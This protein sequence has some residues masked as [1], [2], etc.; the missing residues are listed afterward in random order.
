MKKIIKTFFLAIFLLLLSS[1]V[2]ASFINSVNMDIYIDSNGNA[3][4]T[5]VWDCTPTS[6]TEIYHPYYNLGN[7]EITNLTVSENG[8]EYIFLDYWLYYE[9]LS[10]KKNKCGIRS[11]VDSDSS[12]DR[13]F[14]KA[15]CWGIGSYSNHKY[16]VKYTIT[17]FVSELKDSQM[18]YF[19]FFP[20]HMYQ[21]I[22]KV[23][24]KIYSDF[25]IPSSIDVWGYE[26]PDIG[27]TAHVCNGYI[28]ME[29]DST[30]YAAEERMTILVKFPTGT[31]NTSNKLKNSFNYYYKMA[32]KHN[33]KFYNE[34]IETIFQVI[35]IFFIPPFIILYIQSIPMHR[36]L[37]NRIVIISDYW[38]KNENSLDYCSDIPCD[39]DIF[40]AFYVGYK[41]KIIKNKTDLLGALILKWIKEG[42]CSSKKRLVGI[43]R[44]KEETCIILQKNITFDT[45]FEK[46]L[47]SMLYKASTDGVLEKKELTKWYISKQTKFLAWFNDILSKEKENLI[48]KQKIIV[49]QEKK[50]LGLIKFKKYYTS[51]ELD[52]EAI[53]L[54]GLKKYLLD[55]TLINDREAIDVHLFDEY[56]MYAQLLGIAEKVA[57]QFKDLYPKFVELEQDSYNYTIT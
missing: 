47:Y 36:D 21:S 54:K 35:L 3:N 55:Y 4:V 17:N 28:E 27:N 32:K 16:I 40:E 39:K 5:E 23:Y 50:F 6:G 10:S 13:T 31:F 20:K 37:Y 7:S 30:L 11:I 8:T 19:T 14:G 52:K 26:N 2:H 22:E 38:R 57:K 56:L 15:L 24:I 18:V 45:D 33:S 46:R 34:K 53:R 43:F 44:K 41:Y 25:S 49:T 12:I 29:S 9:T 51:K 48:S 42:K 1:K